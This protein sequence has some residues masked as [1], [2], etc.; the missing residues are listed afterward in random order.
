MFKNYLLTALRVLSR[1]K[2]FSAINI[3]GLTL[4]T[5]C[6]LYILLYV[7]DEYSYD[8]QHHRVGDIY[9]VD[10]YLKS[11]SGEGNR[12]TVVAPVAPL[13]KRDL[14]EVEQFTRVVPFLGVEQH[15]LHYQDKTIYE[16]DAVYADST[17]F[18]VFDFHF[19]RGDVHTALME[20]YSVVLLQPVAARLFGKEDPVGKTI[21][22]EN[23]SF[24]KDYRVTGV[25]DESLGKSHIH[26][27]LFLAMNSGYMGDYVLHSRSWTFNGY[28][29]AYI[30]LRPHTDVALLERKLPAL[31][32]KYGG[33]QLKVAGVENRLFL[34]P[35]SSIHTTT[36]L[37]G[38]QFTTP[39]SPVFLNVLLSIAILIQ[40]IACINFM[41]LSTARAI[42]R[43]REVGIRKVVGA[44]RGH[45]IK[46][47]LGESLLLAFIA[48]VTALPLL[49]LALPWLNDITAADIHW[50]ILLQGRIW[51]ILV[52]LIV[53]TG[54]VAG[55]YPALYLSAFKAI[56]VMKGN[57]ANSISA[58]GIRRGL[59][60]FQFVL[61]IVLISGIVVI[62]S[63]LDF[64]RKKDL[65]FD[66]DQRLV[67][68]FRTEDAIRRVPAFLSDLRGLA[69][70]NEVSNAST[71][72]SSPSFFSNS[73]W[74][75]GQREE[76]G[77][78]A[79]FII[80]DQHFV[81]ASGIRL[82]SGR[83]FRA[84][85]SARILIN[86]TFARMLGLTVQNAPGTFVYDSQSRVEEI[87][88]VMKDFN[89]SKLDK[90][91][92]GFAIWM[93]K[94]KFEIWPIVIASTATA[95]YKDLLGKM[96]AVWHRD[97]PGAPFTY[98]FLDEEVQKQYEAEITM[99]RIIRS[100]TL[101]AILISCLG[102]FG[103]A[104]FSAEQRKKEIGIRK[105]LGATVSGMTRLLS[106]E[107][108][109]LVCIAFVIATPVAGWVMHRWLREFAYRITLQWWMFALAGGLAMFIAVMTVGYQ[110]LKAA[111]GNPVEN[112]REG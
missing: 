67:F 31:V 102:L 28:I 7:T 111:M 76:E 14:P 107:F 4:G 110:A 73:F 24:K 16:K 71:Y 61:S 10:S 39:V 1:N 11:A 27:G 88:G 93:M 66:K 69:G 59:V 101:I 29:S 50:T 41:N 12:A 35:L 79:N 51:F 55:S 46:Q 3:F 87:V 20:P 98:S 52:I 48:L 42:R 25:V 80:S 92:E 65:G 40:L 56:K 70:V 85:D 84:T 47:F 5:L 75:K 81:G 86:E 21:T 104:A 95:D 63:Q 94:P 100:F 45:L 34:Q 32:S 96:E 112:L 77:K 108:L 9:R 58:A 57:F 64:I 109:R 2:T 18:D 99:S 22:V 8:R 36:G 89:Y 83:N 62:Y 72:L 37:G 30:R 97:V 38:P 105:V 78:N 6:C 26:A 90:A 33:D 91:P 103:L 17:F 106:A 13:M 43:A 49:V 19:V 74:L 15:L 60:V 53:V 54:L 82:V 44:G 68:S 23:V